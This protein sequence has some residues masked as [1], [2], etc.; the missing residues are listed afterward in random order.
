M[1]EEKEEK[2]RSFSL[3]RALS[4]VLQQNFPNTQKK[5]L[6]TDSSIPFLSQTVT[7]KRLV[8]LMLTKSNFSP[9]FGLGSLFQVA[10]HCFLTSAVAG[11]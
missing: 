3:S 2:T 5:E 11:S 4:L 7:V 10:D 1:R 8:A 9:H 6:L